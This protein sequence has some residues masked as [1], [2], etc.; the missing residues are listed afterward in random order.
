MY[1]YECY[2][3]EKHYDISNQQKSLTGLR[4][5]RAAPVPPRPLS[6]AISTQALERIVD[7]EESLTSDMEPSKPPSDIGVPSKA[8][9]DIDCS[10][11]NSDIDVNTQSIHQLNRKPKSEIAMCESDCDIQQNCMAESNTEACSKSHS[12]CS[13]IK[14]KAIAPV[15]AIPTVEQARATTKGKLA[16][17]NDLNALFCDSKMRDFSGNSFQY[18]KET[19]C[20]SLAQHDNSTSIK[21]H[22]QRAFCFLFLAF[23]SLRTV[24]AS[25]ARDKS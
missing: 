5:K 14:M 3:F 2:R 1:I 10:K 23:A 7:S 19:D 6:S 20:Q 15:E 16:G 4:K 21:A 11:I 22:L 17:A 25:V 24:F 8:S 9:S 18:R 13:K 12:I